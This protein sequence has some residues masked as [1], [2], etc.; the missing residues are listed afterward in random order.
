MMKHGQPL[1]IAAQIAF[2]AL[3]AGGF[4]GC[5]SEPDGAARQ[6]SFYLNLAQPGVSVD[7]AAATSMVSG[8][9]RNNGLDLVTLD[10]ELMRL[11]EQQANAMAQRDRIDHAISGPFAQRLKGSGYAAKVA[12]ENVGAGY[13]TLAEAFSGWRD[14]PAHRANMLNKNVTRLGIAAVYAP[15]SKYKVFW[16]MVLAAP[17][18][19]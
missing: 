17:A 16:S 4:S 2:A 11:A 6:P 1:R 18:D 5:S 10:P 14:S 3:I 8:Y 7:A 9:R 15:N 19:S 12:V 13:H